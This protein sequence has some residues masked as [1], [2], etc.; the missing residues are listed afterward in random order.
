MQKILLK[1]KTYRWLLYKRYFDLG[2]GLTGYFKW[3]LAVVGISALN[4]Q[5]II[6]GFFFYGIFCF[7]TGWIWIKYN[8]YILENEITNQYNFF[9]REVRENIDK[10][11]NKENIK[12]YST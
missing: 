12:D 3:I 7:L 8:L 9:M 2:Y 10:R 4:L 6:A 1:Q 5:W 11:G